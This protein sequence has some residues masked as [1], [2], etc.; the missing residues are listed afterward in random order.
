MADPVTAQK[1]RID[2]WEELFVCVY[3][4]KINLEDAKNMPVVQRRWWVNRT[5]KELKAIAEAQNGKSN[6]SSTSSAS[7]TQT[8][9]ATDAKIK[10]AFAK[11]K[12]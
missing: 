5:A 2:S 4:G 7:K 6:S 10:N 3:H 9:E 11:Y 12:T 1:R 8:K